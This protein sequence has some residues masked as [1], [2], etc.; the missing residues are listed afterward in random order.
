MNRKIR[1]NIDIMLTGLGIAFIF[2]AVLLGTTLSVRVQMP[3]A[4]VGVLL[5]EAGV[6]GLS[7]KFFPSD[8]RFSRLRVEGNRMLDLV[9]ELNSAAIAK[10][11]GQEDAKRFQATLEEMHNSVIKMS[12]LA[13]V[14]DGKQI[15][16]KDNRV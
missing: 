2:T 7:S 14:E 3:M 16:I 5:M 4:L 11:T 9:R 1:R 15:P 12:E 8:R 10:D 13:G 6:W